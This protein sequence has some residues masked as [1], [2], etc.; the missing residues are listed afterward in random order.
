[1]RAQL[2]LEVRCF[3]TLEPPRGPTPPKPGSPTHV[4]V[5]QDASLDRNTTPRPHDGSRTRAEAR[6]VYHDD[7]PCP[8]RFSER[9]TT[10]GLPDDSQEAD[11]RAAA[12]RLRELRARA[13]SG[14]AVVASTPGLA[15][16]LQR[17]WQK[18]ARFYAKFEVKESQLLRGV[19]TDEV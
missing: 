17:D 4:T 13:K 5:V 16:I 10:S 12:R 2:G 3:G 1:M 7:S 19:P 9:D 14:R 11:E 6:T 8:S 15:E 18:A